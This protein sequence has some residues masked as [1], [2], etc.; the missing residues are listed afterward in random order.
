MFGGIRNHG[1]EGRWSKEGES[2]EKVPLEESFAANEV[3][4]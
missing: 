2:R 1:K 4:Q 3:E